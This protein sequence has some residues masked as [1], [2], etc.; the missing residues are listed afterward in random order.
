MSVCRTVRKVR[1]RGRRNEW[2]LFSS[3]DRSYLQTSGRWREARGERESGARGST[4]RRISGGLFDVEVRHIPLMRALPLSQ[5]CHSAFGQQYQQTDTP[6]CVRPSCSSHVFLSSYSALFISCRPAH[7]WWI[8][9]S[10]HRPHPTHSRALPALLI[11]V[12]PSPPSSSYV[13]C[14][15]L[16]SSL[17]SYL[18]VQGKLPRQR[19]HTYLPISGGLFKVGVRCVPQ[20]P[21]PPTLASSNFVD[22]FATK[23]EMNGNKWMTCEAQR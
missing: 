3:L 7:Q 16:C 6:V 8:L 2:R 18:C 22:P 20:I 23:K 12:H 17:T 13:C 15:V 19:K 14:H 4:D 21:A 5:F 9:R 1:R 10:R 11:L